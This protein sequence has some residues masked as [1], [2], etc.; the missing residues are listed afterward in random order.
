M[1][2]AELRALYDEAKKIIRAERKMRQ[3]VFAHKPD[4]LRIKV[5]EMDRLLNILALLK[6]EAKRHMEP[7]MEQAALIDVPKPVKYE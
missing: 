7:T 2:E 1:T 4:E 5:T 6:D 3:W